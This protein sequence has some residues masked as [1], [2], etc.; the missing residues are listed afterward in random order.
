MHNRPQ[1]KRRIHIEKNTPGRRQPVQLSNLPNEILVK[2][3]RYLTFFDLIG[4]RAVSKKW[5]SSVMQILELETSKESSTDAQS[6]ITKYLSQSSVPNKP[7][8]YL[9]TLATEHNL[10]AIRYML[11][12]LNKTSFSQPRIHYSQYL[13]SEDFQQTHFLGRLGNK[14]IMPKI[15]WKNSSESMNTITRATEYRFF[16]KR[17]ERY[18]ATF[19]LDRLANTQERSNF[20]KS[21]LA[22]K[23]IT[24]NRKRLALQLEQIEDE[25][26]AGN[27]QNPSTT[28][29]SVVLIPENSNG[30]ENTALLQGFLC[31][32]ADTFSAALPLNNR[33]SLESRNI[34]RLFPLI[35]SEQKFSRLFF[36]HFATSDNPKIK[37]IIHH[38][39]LWHNNVTYPEIYKDLL[40]FYPP[41]SGKINLKKL[42]ETGIPK[43]I[44]KKYLHGVGI[45]EK[46]YSVLFHALMLLMQKNLDPVI[47][48]GLNQM[49]CP[50]AQAL[51]NSTGNINEAL[52][53]EL[54]TSLNLS[55]DEESENK[56]TVTRIVF[57]YGYLALF[58]LLLDKITLSLQE[59]NTFLDTEIIIG[60]NE[61]NNIELLIN[62]LITKTTLPETFY[63]KAIAD[64]IQK[65][66]TKIT[67]NNLEAGLVAERI[68]S[69]LLENW[70]NPNKWEILCKKYQKNIYFLNTASMLIEDWRFLNTEPRIKTAIIKTLI[71]EGDIPSV[72]KLVHSNCIHTKAEGT[73]AL[74]YALSTR[75]QEK[76]ERILLTLMQLQK[77]IARRKSSF[78][79]IAESL[80]KEA[81]AA[82]AIEV[83]SWLAKNVITAED[84]P[85]KTALLEQLFRFAI[86]YSDIEMVKLL[87]PQLPNDRVLAPIWKNGTQKNI[88]L[89]FLDQ[90]KSSFLIEGSLLDMEIE[91]LEWLLLNHGALHEQIITVLLEDDS[92]KDLHRY[93]L[94]T[95]IKKNPLLLQTQYWIPNTLWTYS[96]TGFILSKISHATD[97]ISRT[98]CQTVIEEDR[99]N[100]EKMQ[101]ILQQQNVRLFAP[102][103]SAHPAA[104]TTT[105]P[106]PH[107]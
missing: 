96:L 11:S 28:T 78:I 18:P 15:D 44:A 49:H 52:P 26:L 39:V 105:L 10:P 72:E 45:T 69:V 63:T 66:E 54:L 31:D 74:Q 5:H 107:G 106:T 17:I 46:K 34:T 88:G 98:L 59:V 87:T 90:I 62:A 58:A 81:I 85:K 21:L 75:N 22:F 4:S 68:L 30:P 56:V 24:Q 60:E 91:V 103:N 57:H 71:T 79:T 100:Q 82:D 13:A 51:K 2:I 92:T 25:N 7:L 64:F 9:S 67:Q 32:D 93:L 16:L 76:E 6:A 37:E 33:E 19:T 104:P 42:I 94:D 20:F 3:L 40:E 65:I 55:Y 53:K 29:L 101:A 99:K 102:A 43:D 23:E 95:L 77:I 89:H 47:S 97:D 70:E 84:C 41:N 27:L 35:F 36:Q 50:H 1:K 48:K 83:A 38:A 8:A 61:P 73:K 80:T 14:I 12:I 86:F